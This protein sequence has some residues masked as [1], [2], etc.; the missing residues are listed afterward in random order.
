M[1]PVTYSLAAVAAARALERDPLEWALAGGEDHHMLA[2]F[3]T[4]GSVPVSWTVIGRV[5]PG[6][7]VTVDGT[8]PRDL[9]WDHFRT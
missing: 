9:G 1:A 3:P 8:T 4:A 6:A 2:T 7:G 5:E